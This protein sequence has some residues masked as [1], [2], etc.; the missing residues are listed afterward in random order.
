MSDSPRWIKN[1]N[2]GILYM[3]SEILDLR[4]DHLECD[5]DGNVL[6]DPDAAA[7]SEPV[8]LKKR[9]TRKKRTKMTEPAD[10]GEGAFSGDE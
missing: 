9:T 5:A 8:V 1:I 7:S 10:V 3:Y 6:P 4:P 2:S